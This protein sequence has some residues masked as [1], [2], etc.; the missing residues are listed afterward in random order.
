VSPEAG[1]HGTPRATGRDDGN[2]IIIEGVCTVALMLSPLEEHAGPSVFDFV[3]TNLLENGRLT[4]GS[5]HDS[6]VK[7]VHL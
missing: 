4:E 1:H 2:L 3:L 7:S 5:G 6:P